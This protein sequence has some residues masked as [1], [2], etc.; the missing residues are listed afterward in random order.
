MKNVKR[1]ITIVVTLLC[2]VLINCSGGSS[3]SNTDQVKSDD[4]VV[5][6]LRSVTNDSITTNQ[7]NFP[8]IGTTSPTATVTVNG[9]PATVD[10][11]G[12][13]STTLT[14]TLG[15]NTITVLAD[16]NGLQTTVQ[17]TA[18]LQPV[19]P[20]LEVTSP[21]ASLSTNNST[22]TVT[23]SSSTPGVEIWVNDLQQT[24]TSGSFST[25]VTLTSG[26][27]LVRIVAIDTAGNK[28]IVD[29]E[30][31]LDQT[32]PLLAISSPADGATAY[33]EP[34]IITGET[35]PDAMVTVNGNQVTLTADA[36][37]LSAFSETL[38][39][40]EATSNV[41]VVAT[42]SAGNSTTIN[43]TVNRFAEPATLYVANTHPAANNDVNCG[44]S[45]QPCLTITHG[46]SRALITTAPQVL[47]ATGIYQEKVRLVNGVDLL[48]GFNN[49]FTQRNLNSL[50]AEIWGD[51]SSQSVVADGITLPALLEGFV[52][53]GPVMTSPSSNSVALYILDSQS[54]LRVQNNT[55]VAGRAAD[56]LN[57]SDG[58]DGLN[59]MNGEAGNIGLDGITCTA[60]DLKLGGVGGSRIIAAFNLSGGDGGGHNACPDGNTLEVSGAD[61]LGGRFAVGTLDGSGGSGADAGDDGQLFSTTCTL[62]PQPAALFASSGANGMSG[63]N[64]SA[65]AGATSSNIVNHIWVGETGLP[66]S[67][68][69]HGG[70]G[71]G[72]GAGGGAKCVSGVCF[73][74]L[75]GTGGGG[76]S[77]GGSGSAGTGGGFGGSSFGVF[78]SFNATP[79][80]L[81]VITGNEIFTGIGGNGGRGGDGGIGGNGGAG[82]PGGITA[83]DAFCSGAGGDGGDG[84]DG[85]VGAGGGGGTGGISAG[86][87]INQAGYSGGYSY[88]IDNVINTTS[89]LSG[90]GGNGGQSLGDSGV[91]G[92]TGSIN[93]VLINP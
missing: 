51:G 10:A 72:G 46:L 66:G 25:S 55:L 32:Q 59:G 27:N 12:N 54:S 60:A 88:D 78:I 39:T 61:G 52:I 81:P 35:E 28:T 77:G 56:G 2:F 76:G 86:I 41:A 82:A 75:G 48:G 17:F 67:A 9:I 11:A 45:T 64:G 92:S 44:T 16:L 58:L 6:I 23:G 83:I 57:G 34:L 38:A 15:A 19:P 4:P 5:L 40:Y 33:V 84:G 53:R 13:F 31:I 89:G 62:P 29:R 71:G 21:A 69:G 63:A 90:V 42:D 70:G 49:S 80:T 7:S 50:K 36:G 79:T 73:D 43:L 87:F 18:T 65:A 22:L 30:V 24:L 8:I 91:A 85:G 47:V 93:D 37:S 1:L 3:S 26:S 68:G 74:M 14:L 20:S